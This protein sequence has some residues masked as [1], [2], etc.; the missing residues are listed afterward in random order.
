MTAHY[1]K[2]SDSAARKYAEV[3]D[4]TPIDNDGAGD[5]NGG[6]ETE[7]ARARLIELARTLPIDKVKSILTALEG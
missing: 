4:I 5:A 6:D 7:D 3:I 1:E 2:I